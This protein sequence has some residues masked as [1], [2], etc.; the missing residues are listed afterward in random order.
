[1][2]RLERWVVSLDQNEKIAKARICH[3]AF[4]SS[5]FKHFIDVLRNIEA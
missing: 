2:G 5:P 4:I 3:F 1:M